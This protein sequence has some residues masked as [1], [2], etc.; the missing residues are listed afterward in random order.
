MTDIKD[1]EKLKA[2]VKAGEAQ[3]KGP[4]KNAPSAM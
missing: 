2:F 1:I 4:E 3:Y